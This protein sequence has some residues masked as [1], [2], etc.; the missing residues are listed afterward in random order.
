MTENPLDGPDPIPGHDSDSLNVIDVVVDGPGDTTVRPVTGKRR[1]MLLAEREKIA[2]W[3]EWRQQQ[4][5][6]GKSPKSADSDNVQ[7]EEV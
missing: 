6:E 2:R 3:M 1:E 7:I 5:A 4:E